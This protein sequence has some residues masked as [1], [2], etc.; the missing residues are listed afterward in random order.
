[1]KTV[2]FI[3]K[4][5][6]TIYKGSFS[7]PVIRIAV[8]S[9]ALSVAVMIV[10]LAIVKGFKLEIQNKVIGFGSHIK[11]NKFQTSA[12][13]ELIPVNMSREDV[14]TLKDRVSIISSVAGVSEKTGIIKTEDQILGCI[15]KGVTY[16]YHWDYLESWLLEG[17]LPALSEDS[18]SDDVIISKSIG[19]KMYLGVGDYVRV[20]FLLPDEQQ[21]RGRRFVVSGI[22]NSGL[23]EFDENYIFGDIKHL[24]TLNGW[25][26]NEVG[27]IEILVDDFENIIIAK[28]KIHEIIDFDLQVS[29]VQELE[30]EIFNWLELLNMNVYVIIIIMLLVATINIITILLIRILEKTSAIGIL[31]SMGATNLLIR[32][33]FIYVSSSILIRGIIIGNVIALSLC[34]IQKYFKVIKLPQETYYVDTVPVYLNLQEIIFLNTGIFIIGVLVMLIPS[35]IISRIYPAE[36]LRLR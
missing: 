2:S 11:I 27:S 8:V 13:E 30:P 28:S 16:D 10:S 3:G 32:K 5:F 6:S 21:P 18:V 9:V 23:S 17:K 22:Y 15:V 34:F 25:N 26:K 36:T 12:S 33:I 24:Q 4:R 29:T 19:N 14:A 31:K 35:M 7:R 1:V 20:F